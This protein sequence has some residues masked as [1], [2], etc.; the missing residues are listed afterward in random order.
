[1]ENVLALH[2]WPPTRINSDRLQSGYHGVRPLHAELAR[3]TCP[4]AAKTRSHKATKREKWHRISDPGSQGVACRS[5]TAIE[6]AASSF[7]LRLEAYPYRP[8]R[9]PNASDLDGMSVYS[10]PCPFHNLVPH[11]CPYH[12]STTMLSRPYATRSL[13]YVRM[14]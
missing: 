4:K 11:C 2:L 1:M 7:S 9:A 6:V 8:S 3:S 12:S 14:I 13:A 5:A 10:K